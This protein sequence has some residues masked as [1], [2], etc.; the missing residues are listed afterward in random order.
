VTKRSVSPFDGLYALPGFPL[1]LLTV[2]QNV[3]TVVSFHYYSHKPPSVMVGIRPDN[4]SFKLLQE[5]RVF[6]VNL[7]RRDMVEVARQCGTITGRT[8]DKFARV[9][10]TRAPATKIDGV[11]VAECPVSLECSVVHE[12]DFPSTHHWFV[13]KIEA[14]HVDDAYLREH[15]LLYWMSEF[16][17]VG[18]LLL[19]DTSL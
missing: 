2:G 6:A 16:R 1:T 8:Q 9:G 3:L 5:K 12:V 14:A 7:L 13:G 11:L 4:Y 17:G 15:A 19:K 18:E 10:L